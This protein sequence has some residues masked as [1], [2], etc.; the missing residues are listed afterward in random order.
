M[1]NTYEYS[2][3]KAVNSSDLENKI[4]M[5]LGRIGFREI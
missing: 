2:N 1:L 3:K 4:N 5:T